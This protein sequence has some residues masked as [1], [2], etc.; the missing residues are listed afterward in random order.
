MIIGLS[1][2]DGKFNINFDESSNKR[3]KGK[4]LLNFPTDFTVVDLETTGTDPRF[5]DMIEICCIKYRN[6]TEIE[7]FQ[8]LI[9]PDD[10][11]NIPEFIT[12]ITGIT[13]EM[14]KTAPHFS[15]I[16]DQVFTFIENEVL[17]GHNV[18]FDINFLYDW[19]F[20][21]QNKKINNDYVDTLRL[22]RWILPELSHHR[23]IDLCEYYSI[24]SIHHRSAAD[25]ESTKI[26]LDRLKNDA[27]L[28]DV[29]FKKSSGKGGTKLDL[30]EI[31]GDET[32]FLE[33]HPFYKKNCV[34]TGKLEKFERKDAAQLVCNIGGI[35]ENGVTSK[36]NY[37]IVGDFDY[38]ANIKDGKSTKLKKAE[39]LILKGQDL[40]IISENTFYCMLED[41]FDS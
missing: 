5:D 6:N 22:S 16:A 20:Y 4:S 21:N 33:D 15:E 40:Q 12:T 37:L 36:T 18:N 23:L 34:F 25:C 27:E 2:T 26:V 29:K 14:L 24:D 28:R 9:Q 13:N 8:S 30:R 11:A 10:G 38:S 1:I 31:H 3:G 17:V 39:Q 32:L 35:C 41:A 19:F 7:R